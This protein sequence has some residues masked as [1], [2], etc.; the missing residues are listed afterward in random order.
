MNER[1]RAAW[2]LAIRKSCRGEPVPPEEHRAL[3]HK[4]LF[5]G[6]AKGAVEEEARYVVRYLLSGVDLTDIPP[7]GPREAENWFAMREEW[8]ARRQAE[9]LR[10]MIAASK[11]DPDYWTALN[12]VAIRI[13]AERRRWPAILADWDIEVRRGRRSKPPQ[14]RGNKGQPAYAKDSRN[15]WIAYAFGVLVYLGLGKMESYH[16]PR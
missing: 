10:N 2:N 4:D 11:H 12:H 7:R 5:Q 15:L 9:K 1:R 8:G 3:L 6:L 14:P 16:H 13:Q